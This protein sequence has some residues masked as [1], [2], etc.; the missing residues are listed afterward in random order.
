MESRFL[1]DV[2]TEIRDVLNWFTVERAQGVP[3]DELRE[4]AARFLAAM[5]DDGA[6]L[7]EM[8]EDLTPQK[9]ALVLLHHVRSPKSA[10]AWL[11]LGLALRR[12]AL[13]RT[14]DPEHINRRRVLLALEALDRALQLDPDNTGKNTRA[15]TG[16]SFAYHALGLFENE[17]QCCFRALEADRSDP[18][19]WL[20][21]GFALRSAGRKGEALSVMDDAYQA[22]VAA[23]EPEELRS[24][25]A[26]IR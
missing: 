14:Q 19:L 10:G 15:W 13:C 6:V 3:S 12:M 11:N 18:K 22:Y 7:P 21:Y 17:V 1:E 9:L 8:R 5:H 4:F 23:G 25:F 2:P 20:L 24:V 26:G 16:E